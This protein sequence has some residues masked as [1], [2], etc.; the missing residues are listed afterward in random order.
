M[1]TNLIANAIVAAAMLNARLTNAAPT[2]T[3]VNLTA[4]LSAF[5]Q[6]NTQVT[7]AA[8]ALL[9]NPSAATLSVCNSMCMCISIRRADTP[10]SQ[11]AV[12]GGNTLIGLAGAVNVVAQVN[13]M[14]LIL[15]C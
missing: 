9:A 5:T 2:A 3:V 11:A 7:S 14:P 4:K 8:Q 12:A 6:A 1:A 13:Q 15:R 10:Y